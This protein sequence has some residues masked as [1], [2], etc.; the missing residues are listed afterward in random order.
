MYRKCPYCGASLDPGEQCD[1][2]KEE[3][4]PAIEP[5]AAMVGDN[6]IIAQQNTQIKGDIRTL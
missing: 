6:L 1:C 3:A 2:Q 4:A 5:E